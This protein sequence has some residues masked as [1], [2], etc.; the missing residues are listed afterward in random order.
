MEIRILRADAALND[1]EALD[2]LLEPVVDQLAFRKALAAKEP[3]LGQL[4]HEETGREHWIASDGRSVCCL[5]VSG[6]TKV[7]AENVR[8][9]WRQLYIDVGVTPALDEKM[10][11]QVVK[12]VI[13]GNVRI[14]G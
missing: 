6:L 14:T 1:A 4:W 11:A 13:G 10:V 8:A 5:T 9:R 12:Q 3:Y 7:Q 2:K